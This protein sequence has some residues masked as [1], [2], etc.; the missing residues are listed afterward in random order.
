MTAITTTELTKQYGSVTA[1]NDVDL[2]VGEGEIYGFVGPNGAGKSTTID[3]L[4]DYTR[5]TD[6]TATVLGHDTRE[7]TLA[8]H[9]RVGI[10][11]DRFGLYDRL[12]GRRHVEYVIDSKA[13]DDDP[14]ECLERVG[15]VDAATRKASE[16]SKGMQQRLAL[17]MA[18]VGAPDL[19]VLDE[20]FTGLDPNGVR[21]VREVIGE[22]ND[23]GATVFFSSHVLGEIE[24]VCDRIGLLSA[25]SLVA[26][27]TIA[28]LREDVDAD[29]QLVLTIDS[30]ANGIEAPVR[31]IE[32]VRGV[33]ID[34]DT[35]SVTCRDAE[36]RRPVID[37]VEGAGA[38]I[39]EFTI[40]EPTVEDLFVAYTDDERT[41]A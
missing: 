23:R 25:G 14:M 5:P 36:L 16:Y 29:P 24:L 19:L 26:E 30:T 34:G 13:S 32:G 27:G 40:Q 9:R 3:I 4:M 20:P 11:P 41:N 33:T 18:L 7:D 17:A 22:E 21:R 1:L 10:L 12:T 15:L 37:A 31:T 39:T 35:V 8:V 2:E 38:S 28:E 6:G